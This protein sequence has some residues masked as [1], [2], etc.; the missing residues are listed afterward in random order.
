MF[1]IISNVHV[2]LSGR[3]RCLAS[4]T[5]I[6]FT[7]DERCQGE[8]VWKHILFLS[9]CQNSSK[10]LSVTYPMKTADLIMNCFSS[11]NTTDHT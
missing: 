1:K 6:H 10:F 7:T 2:L 3:A 4:G 5:N 8:N 11:H 9:H